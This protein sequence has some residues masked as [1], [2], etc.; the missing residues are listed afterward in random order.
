MVAV[1]DTTPTFWMAVDSGV[2]TVVV[3]AVAVAV[4][5]A[6]VVVAV[7]VAAVV[8]A[9]VTAAPFSVFAAVVFGQSVQS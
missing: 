5:V 9:V 7:V 2:V 3:V 6:V 1:T 8:V 4:V